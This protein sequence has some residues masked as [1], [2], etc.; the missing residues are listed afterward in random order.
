MQR[1]PQIEENALNN[2]RPFRSTDYIHTNV[3]I[4]ITKS[5][6]ETQKSSGSP[7]GTGRARSCSG[8][9]N[10]ATSP[11]VL[12]RKGSWMKFEKEKKIN[13]YLASCGHA[14]SNAD[15]DKRTRKITH[16]IAELF[17]LIKEN[18]SDR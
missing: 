15:I 4:P 2:P 13:S 11:P 8:G 14:E 1:F 5:P 3:E 6:S 10:K 9:R 7:G 16:R 17:S 12:S 18:Q